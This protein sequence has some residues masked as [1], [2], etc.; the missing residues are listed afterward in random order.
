MKEQ[1][2]EICRRLGKKECGYHQFRNQFL[3]RFSKSQLQENQFAQT[4]SSIN[5]NQQQNSSLTI[6]GHTRTLTPTKITVSPS[7]IEQNRI[8]FN[9]QQPQQTPFRQ[10]VVN[11]PVSHPQARIYTTPPKIIQSIAPPPLS[12][13]TVY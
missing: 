6:S 2:C 1:S 7:R 12:P 11:T 3:S 9:Y 4:Q 8:N 10:I 13:R 5:R